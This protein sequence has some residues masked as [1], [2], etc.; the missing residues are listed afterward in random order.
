[1]A[2]G[3]GFEPPEGSSPSAVFKTAA[4][5]RTLPSAHHQYS[6]SLCYPFLFIYATSF[7]DGYEEEAGFE[8]A[9]DLSVFIRF[10]NER[11]Q[12]L[13]PLFLIAV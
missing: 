4:L 2:G 6:L 7:L 1:M 9:K 13:E 12:P 8:P 11:H 3:E 10:R 5:N